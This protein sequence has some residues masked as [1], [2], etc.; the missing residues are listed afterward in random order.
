MP[1]C[2]SCRAEIVWANTPNGKLIPLDAEPTAD[3]NVTLTT[4]SPVTAV[5]LGPLELQL[6][7]PSVPRFA[8]HFARC[9]DADSWRR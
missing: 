1:N 6:L 8:A 9:P 5:V 4:T 2:R 7:D 3:G